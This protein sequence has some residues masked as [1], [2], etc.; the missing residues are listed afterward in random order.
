MRRKVMVFSVVIL[1]VTLLGCRE[2]APKARTLKAAYNKVKVGMSWAEMDEIIGVS[3]RTVE[4]EFDGR[5]VY[6][7]PMPGGEGSVRAIF[8]MKDGKVVSKEWEEVREEM[9]APTEEDV[10]RPG[11]ELE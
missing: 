3:G 2:R 6:Q 4:E 9:R 11:E 1:A 10:D 8:H 7:A 5:C